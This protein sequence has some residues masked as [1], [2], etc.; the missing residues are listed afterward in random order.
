[1]LRAALQFLRLSEALKPNV[2]RR[3]FSI[4]FSRRQSCMQFLV[5]AFTWAAARSLYY[6][7][8]ALYLPNL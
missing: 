5:E 3:A 8:L 1:M 4:S 6:L 7:P 2:I